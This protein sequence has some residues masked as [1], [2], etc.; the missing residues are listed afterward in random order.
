MFLLL[1][2]LLRF[3]SI[4][5]IWRQ[6]KRKAAAGTRSSSEM[7]LIMEKL[8]DRDAT[9]KRAYCDWQRSSYYRLGIGGSSV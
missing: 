6:A 1:R 5:K 9:A 2:A 3:S 8:V 4:M 7:K